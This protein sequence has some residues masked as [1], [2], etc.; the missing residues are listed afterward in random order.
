VTTLLHDRG[1][2]ERILPHRSYRHLPVRLP[3]LLG[4]ASV[5]IMVEVLVVLCAQRGL[6]VMAGFAAFIARSDGMAVRQFNDPF[7]F[8][9][10]HPIAFAM[11]HSD[12][13]GQLAVVC[14]CTAIVIGLSIWRAIATPIRIFINLNALLIGAAA[15]FLFLAGHL[16]YD[17]ASFSQL[18][19]RTALVTWL[20]IP[21]SVACFALLFPFRVR[22]QLLFI[23]LAVAWDIP[24]SIARYA[25]FI[26]ILGKTGSIAMTDLY[27]IFGPLLDIVPIICFL[28]ILLVRLGN[29]LQQRSIEWGR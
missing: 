21:I 25:C 6:D 27:F 18:M 14:V 3:G 24:L 13:F 9:T 22:E 16:G 28:S 2:N 11:P 4:T 15:L 1:I 20:V 26:V 5:A 8:V 29:A 7:L 10:L 17:S 23:T 19:V 12:W